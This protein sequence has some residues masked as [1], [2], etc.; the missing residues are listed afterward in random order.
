[1]DL[2]DDL[3]L[4]HESVILLPTVNHYLAFTWLS[5]DPNLSKDSYIE[6]LSSNANPI[7][8]YCNCPLRHIE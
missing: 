3:D 7:H 6:Q 2:Y 8:P 1:M 5:S 4:S